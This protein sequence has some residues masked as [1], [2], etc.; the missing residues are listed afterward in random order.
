MKKI[1]TYFL[2]VLFV[3]QSTSNVWIISSFYINRDY[4]A[5]ELCINRFDKMP[6]CKGKCYLEKKIADNEKKEQ[7][8]P[9]A[10]EKEIQFYFSPEIASVCHLFAPIEYSAC[11][12]VGKDDGISSTFPYS[13]FHPPK[14]A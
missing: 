2:L 5:K 7:K 6:V 14:S 11:I 1:V 3:F 9:N 8:I 10:K 12:A 13:I 4:I